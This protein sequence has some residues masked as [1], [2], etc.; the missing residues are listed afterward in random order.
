MA[1]GAVAG[2]SAVISGDVSSP[3]APAHGFSFSRRFGQD[4]PVLFQGT[5]K[6]DRAILFETSGQENSCA[7]AEGE[8]KDTSLKYYFSTFKASLFQSAC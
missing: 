5:L 8:L 1:P 6:K 7:G 4:C 2:R 3:S